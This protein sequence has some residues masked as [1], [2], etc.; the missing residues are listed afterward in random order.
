LFDYFDAG[1]PAYVI[2]NHVNYS[3][4][5]NLEQMELINAELSTLNDTIQSP[6]YSWVGPFNNFISEGVWKDDCNSS[7]ASILPFDD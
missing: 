5:N 7:L 2:F 1:P 4:P 6:I 3:D